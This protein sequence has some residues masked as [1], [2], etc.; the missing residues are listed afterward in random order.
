MK[1][2]KIGVFAIAVVI[3]GGV[4]WWQNNAKPP[5]HGIEVKIPA[6]TAKAE[7]G[8]RL[9]ARNCASCHGE[10]A[11]GSDKGPPLIHKIYEPNHHG[12][13]S[14][15]R[16]ALQGVRAHHWPYGDMPSV[17]GITQD[18]VANIIRF[19]REVQKYNGI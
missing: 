17:P 7:I 6:L 12:D 18:E 15:Y 14:F 8:G 9:F 11:A 13:G 10:Y 1:I 3:A 19:I 5:K 16:A 2:A 4:Y